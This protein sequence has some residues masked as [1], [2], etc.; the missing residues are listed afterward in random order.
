M[1]ISFGTSL[2]AS[3][4]ERTKTIK[5]PPMGLFDYGITATQKGKIIVYGGV[6]CN[7]SITR[8][9]RSLILHSGLWYVNIA[10]KNP[11]FFLVNWP[12]SS[13]GFSRIVSLEGDTICILNKNQILILDSEKMVFYQSINDN[14]FDFEVQRNGFGVGVAN[15]SVIIIGGYNEFGAKIQ[16]IKSPIIFLIKFS[17]LLFPD[18]LFINYD[19][20]SL[21]TLSVGCVCIMISVFIKKKCSEPYSVKSLEIK[22][23]N[24]GFDNA[25]IS[26]E[27]SKSKGTKVT[28]GTNFKLSG[29]LADQTKEQDL[30]DNPSLM[31]PSSFRGQLNIDYLIE[32][33]LIVGGFST[34]SVGCLLEENV[35]NEQNH[36]DISCIVKTISNSEFFQREA[37]THY[38]FREDKYFS[39]LIYD[40]REHFQIVLRYYRYGSLY[41]YL[42]K[43]ITIIPIP[44]SLNVS[45]DLAERIT[46][47]INTMHSRGY[48]HNDINPSNILLHAD[49]NEIL[50]P[51]I[52]DFG[53]VHLIN[54][55]ID[56]ENCKKVKLEYCAPEM[57]LG[58]KQKIAKVANFK[59]DIYSFGIVLINIFTRN[60]A[61]KNFKKEI[62]MEGELPDITVSNLSKNFQNLDP[63][64]AVYMMGVIYSCID[65]DVEIRPS[66]DTVNLKLKRLQDMLGKQ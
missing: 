23:P 29:S 26:S 40:C 12:E 32:K 20:Y 60:T 6:T 64:I 28:A 10:D 15:E 54:M 62:V 35:I 51:V 53:L 58:F 19:V 25:Y 34:I 55:N 4:W 30:E 11:D 65:H 13:G 16:E 45:I 33:E 31:P 7:G 17:K 50:F 49:K 38:L 48:I 66:I 39:K 8:A 36:G 14:P 59:T 57:L 37:S 46:F 42:F 63:K 3:E 27:V 18:K 52:T 2:L 61:W 5:H 22:N 1:E 21:G 44:Y 9:H 56:M 41:N 43:K 47:A 24:S